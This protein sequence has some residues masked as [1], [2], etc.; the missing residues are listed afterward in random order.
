MASNYVFVSG[1]DPKMYEDYINKRMAVGE[2]GLKFHA[3]VKNTNQQFAFKKYRC[4]LNSV[5][6]KSI[7]FD[8][9]LSQP[10]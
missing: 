8:S 10:Q 3:L 6:V 7:D 5:G 4:Q 2:N 1:F 9:L